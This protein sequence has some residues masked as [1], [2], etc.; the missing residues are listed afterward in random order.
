MKKVVAILLALL[1]CCTIFPF[2]AFAEDADVDVD[3]EIE[4]SAE[5]T[6]A[7]WEANYGILLK[8]LMNGTNYAHYKYVLDNDKE[9]QQL[10]D[11]YTAFGL[12][13][14]AW[15][16]YF[17]KEANIDTCKQILM[18][19]I[20]KYSVEMGN[21]YVDAIVDGLET[22]KDA[23]EFVEKL[24]GYLNE[25]SD[26]LSFVESAEWS[27]IFSVV[28]AL[29]KIGNAWADIRDGLI[30]AYSQIM[31]VQ[32]ANGYYIE[33][34]QYVAN[35]TPYEPMKTAALALIEEA[36]TAV[37]EQIAYFLQ[38]ATEDLQNQGINALVNLAVNSNVYTATAKKIFN[39]A[40]SVADVLWNTSDQYALFDALVA[41]VYAEN[42]ITDYTALSYSHYVDS[43]DASRTMFA[44]Y[45]LISVRMF[46]EQSLYNLL[47]AQA[48]GII[49]K[50]KSK[51]YNTSCTEYTANMAALT[52]TEEALFNTAVADMAPVEAVAYIYC[53]VNVLVYDD[54][55]LLFRVKDGEE[56]VY[57]SSFGMAK[58]SYCEYNKEYIK[59]AFLK[60][61]DYKIV[62]I[63]TDDGYVTFVK[64]VMEDGVLNDYSFTEVAVTPNT[65]ITVSGKKYIV[66]RDNTNLE[67]DLNDE[68]VQPEGKEVTWETV[69]EA[70]KEVVKEETNNFFAKIKAFF[71]NFFAKLKEL[72]T[73]KK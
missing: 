40:A 56:S 71:Q 5:D 8:T 10:M 62:M 65:K 18:A 45:A 3:S 63:G 32:L 61:A 24:N 73:I 21:S 27:T 9:I 34:L 17:T 42:A 26:V 33:M 22:A 36:T 31:S 16:N 46:G 20:E 12:Y 50:I 30:E 67:V 35:N 59:V 58:A 38:E 48:G 47:E 52:L 49:N 60:D 69:T 1:M 29:I 55:T 13:D 15:K 44:T 43:F 41:S 7:A 72:F 6:V 54:S 19:M 14:N 39:G 51:V 4:A 11:V 57:T 66:S 37:E 68:F 25:Y 28:D 2:A 70:T 64:D 53:P 23:A